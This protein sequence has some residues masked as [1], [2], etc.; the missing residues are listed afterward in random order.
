MRKLLA[1][2]SFCFPT[3]LFAATPSAVMTGAIVNNWT[4]A[5][6]RV[7]DKPFDLAI[8]GNGFFVLQLTN[9]E[10]VFSRYGEMGLSPDGYLIH[11]ASY[12]KVLGNCDGELR[13]INLSEFSM[14]EKGTTIKSFR[15]ELDGKIMAI[16]ESGY[17]HQSCTVVLALFSNPNKLSR[18]KHILRVTPESGSPFIGAAHQEARGSI[19]DSSLEEL[20]EQMYRLNIKPANVDRVVVEM[21]KERLAKEDWIKK[22]TLFYVYDLNV[23]R[24]DL[25]EIEKS[26]EKYGVIIKGVVDL[27]EGPGGI[28]DNE[29]L[30][31]IDA[32]SKLHESEVL[33]ILGQN[34]FDKAKQ[35][36]EDYNTQVWAKFGTSL[37]FTGF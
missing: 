29:F 15:T 24:Q 7:S 6:V 36:R 4:Q 18:D 13:P 1:T 5:G 21:E 30:S 35:F 25:A 32:A 17:T 23:S 37:R 8:Q 26:Y 10:Q 19:Y 20:D 9:G 11:A 34:R 3:V 22:K 27:T 16:Y 33:K 2:F 28:S 12:G 31:K 14:D